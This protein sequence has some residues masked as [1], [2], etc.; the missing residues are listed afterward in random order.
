MG[1]VGCVGVVVDG[2]EDDRASPWHGVGQ[3]GA[4]QFVGVVA[5]FEIFHLAGATVVD[6]PGKE[7]MFR[8]IGDSGNAAEIEAEFE[9]DGL[10][11]SLELEDRGHGG[12]GSII[13]SAVRPRSRKTRDLGHPAWGYGLASTVRNGPRFRKARNLGHPPRSAGYNSFDIFRKCTGWVNFVV[14][15]RT[16]VPV[17]TN[18]NLR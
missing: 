11:L 3:R 4:L 18:P 5:S 7:A 10:E 14:S 6:P 9:S 12:L 2:A 13:R 17:S 16:S 1:R 8:R 15:E